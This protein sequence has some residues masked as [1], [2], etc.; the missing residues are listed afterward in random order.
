MQERHSW[1][2]KTQLCKRLI[3]GG[4]Y[5]TWL[6]C[7]QVKD[8]LVMWEPCCASPK[9]NEDHCFSVAAIMKKW[10][11]EV[12]PNRRTQT[13]GNLVCPKPSFGNHLK[14][15]M[16][17]LDK[18]ESR[19]HALQR[20]S[21]IDSDILWNSVCREPSLLHNTWRKTAGSALVC[22]W[23]ASCLEASAHALFQTHMNIKLG[24]AG[25]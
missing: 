6:S 15:R 1:K 20:T 17:S 3:E 14:T 24:G 25:L 23:A 10:E 9:N 22:T 18:T 2:V 16:S 13:L 11:K 19:S 8:L 5:K 21:I 12:I 7:N 4:E